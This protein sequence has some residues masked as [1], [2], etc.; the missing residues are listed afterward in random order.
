MARAL[1]L[2]ALAE[3]QTTPNPLVGCVVLDATGQLVGEGYH[4]RAGEPHA[5]VMALRR[6]GERARGGTL[7]VTLE[8]CC[9][10]GRTPPCT[11]AVIAAGI[12]KVVVALT[13]PD[14]RVAGGGIS[15]LQ[16]G[17]C[18]DQGCLRC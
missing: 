12:T 6:A 4:R 16:R 5:E 13:D 8:P 18:C 17:Y 15:Q 7:Y 10:H 11:E 14:P 1:A 2:A 9:H 3:G